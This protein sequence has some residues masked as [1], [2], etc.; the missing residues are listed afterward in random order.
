[1]T[2]RLR[3]AR[4]M[5]ALALVAAAAAVALHATPGVTTGHY[6]LAVILTVAAIACLPPEVTR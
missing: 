2:R 3:L 4:S 1:M 5:G 6:L